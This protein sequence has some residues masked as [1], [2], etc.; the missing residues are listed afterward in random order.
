ML[1]NARSRTVSKEKGKAR[2][3][4]KPSETHGQARSRG[5]S[6]S[7]VKA[8]EER[9]GEAV[10]F[11]DQDERDGAE[12]KYAANSPVKGKR[13]LDSQVGSPKI[14]PLPHANSIIEGFSQG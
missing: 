9:D 2:E 10:G 13:R 1:F 8:K 11:S 6:R 3:A 4:T 7:I 12:R 5:V 14:G